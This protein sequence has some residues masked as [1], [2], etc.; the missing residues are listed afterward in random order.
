[1][2]NRLNEHNLK[3]NNKIAL[4]RCHPEASAYAECIQGR[5]FSM[6]YYCREIFNELNECLKLKCVH[7]RRRSSR[8]P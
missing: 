1:V 7:C 5:T 2:Q 4:E 3:K 6:V 8:P